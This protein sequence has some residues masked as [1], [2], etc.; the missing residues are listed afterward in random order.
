MIRW[1]HP[2]RGILAPAEFLLLLAG[3]DLEFLIGEWV[4][5]TALIQIEAWQAAGLDFGI[6][7]NV[8]ARHLQ[9]PGF[10]FCLEQLLGR[11]PQALAG[12]LELEILESAALD[13]LDQAAQV[14]TD[15]KALGV[16]FAL[17][18]FGT[19]YSSLSY[20]RQLP[21][22]TLKID[23]SFV[24]NMLADAGDL[25][26]VQSVIHLA[27]TFGRA[28]IAEGVED[29]AYGEMLVNLGCLYG[30]GY[31]IARPMPAD[32]MPAWLARWQFEKAWCQPGRLVPASKH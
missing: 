21:V 11:H 8:G 22:E 9:R 18:D 17:D 29:L 16:H 32:E 28:V 26:I 30:Q 3:S 27:Q 2:E 10:V 19:G 23:Q 4:I 12:R 20:F 7:V 14:L 15:C 13:D 5:E 31:A 25:G 24:R 6:S 1:Q